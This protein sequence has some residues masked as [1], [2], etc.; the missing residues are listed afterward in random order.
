MTGDIGEF[1]KYGHLRIIDRKKNLVKSL[2]G[3]YIALEKLESVYRST[4]VVGNICV[5]VAPDQAKPVAI[6]VPV[7]AALLQ[8]AKSNGIHGESLE[9]LIHDEKVSSLVLK[10]LQAVGKASGLRGFEIIEGVVLSDEEWTPQSVSFVILRFCPG[11]ERMIVTNGR[12]LVHIQGYVTAA[13]K[14][15][16]KKIMN[17]FQKEIDHAYGKD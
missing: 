1:D 8:L 12:F 4:H 9:S 3:E 5:Y 17:H 16:R 7:E 13:Q 10:E 15:Q 2:N 11:P 6:I 14:I